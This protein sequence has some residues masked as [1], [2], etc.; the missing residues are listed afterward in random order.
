VQFVRR[1]EVEGCEKFVG[2]VSVH[3]SFQDRKQKAEGKKGQK[4]R[5]LTFSHFNWIVILAVL[6]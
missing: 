2:T 6:H 1:Q 5:I 4:I 3:K